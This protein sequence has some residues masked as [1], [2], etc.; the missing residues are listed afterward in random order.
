MVEIGKLRPG[1]GCSRL[2]PGRLLVLAALSFLVGLYPLLI[3]A[4]E[5][6]P[7][8]SSKLSGRQLKPYGPYFISFL[9]L[10]VCGLPIC[11]LHGTTH[12]STYLLL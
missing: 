9:P 2:T 1:R 3:K 8:T 11:S 7:R 12:L 6:E 5:A 10:P 4:V